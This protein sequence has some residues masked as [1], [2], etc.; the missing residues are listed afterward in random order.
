MH[1]LHTF[2]TPEPTTLEIRNAAGDVVVTLTDTET[3]SVEVTA[4]QGQGFEFLDRVLR[5]VPWN[6][7]GDPDAG[8]GDPAARVRVE[9]RNGTIVIDTDT[10]R[11]GWRSS[12]LVVVTAPVGSGVRVQS[13]SADIRI[14]GRAGRAEVRTASGEVQVDDVDGG[15]LLQ[16]ASG[17]VHIR[18]VGGDLDAKTASGNITADTVGG[19][20]TVVTTSGDVRLAGAAE[21]IV[22]RSVSGDVRI[23]DAVRGRVEATSVSG[24]VEIGVHPG[25]GATVSLSTLTGDTNTDFE[26]TDAPADPIAGPVLD[27]KVKTTSGDIRLRRAVPA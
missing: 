17:D 27:I 12:F 23:A 5:N 8:A 2:A 13:Q 19:V 10:A 14:S 18:Q 7:G 26:V 24:D 11:Q 9:E 25:S 20:A 21:G 6:P 15:A 4:V 22:G 1:M 16:T 3:A